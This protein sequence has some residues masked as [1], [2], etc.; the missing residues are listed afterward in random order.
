[1]PQFER[2]TAPENLPNVAFF[3]SG[4]SRRRPSRD[5]LT[6]Y[7][8]LIAADGP[9]KPV[10]SLFRRGDKV[11]VHDLRTRHAATI[12]R[13]HSDGRPMMVV[14]GVTGPLAH[15]G[16]TV[17]KLRETYEY[18][19]EYDDG[20]G[21]D[22]RVPED[23]LTIKEAEVLTARTKRARDRAADDGDSSD[24][25]QRRSSR[26]VSTAEFNQACGPR[27]AY[28]DVGQ[29]DDECDSSKPDESDDASRSRAESDESDDDDVDLVDEDGNEYVDH[30]D[31]DDDEYKKNFFR[32]A[33][34]IAKSTSLLTID[35]AAIDTNTT[36][37]SME[38]VTDYVKAVPM[39]SIRWRLYFPRKKVPGSRNTQI[40]SHHQLVD[41]SRTV[42]RSFIKYNELEWYR[43][44]FG[45]VDL[46]F[47]EHTVGEIAS[48]EDGC[49]V[50]IALRG[51]CED[52]NRNF[53]FTAM[54]IIANEGL[55]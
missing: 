3:A 16:Q 24:D 41:G 36:I 43:T 37:A 8:E 17:Y 35:R 39:L 22:E 21:V 28:D 38:D 44:V 55:G 1:M 13:V 52:S 6:A 46:R 25:G 50:D 19:V 51:R 31:D 27:L 54:E 10:D 2:S 23:A 29:S 7:Q 9:W 18:D 42:L 14:D 49:Y 11:E 47:L 53:A 30:P 34:Y 5:H 12:R 4:D 33:A 48:D 45:H 15:G 26:R 20:S 40:P 32:P